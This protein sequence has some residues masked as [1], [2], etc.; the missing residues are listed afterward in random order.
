[1]NRLHFEYL[2]ESKK[3]EEDIHANDP[4]SKL[5]KTWS[6]IKN[7]LKLQPLWDIRDYLGEYVAFYYAFCGVLITS[8]W[9]PSLA[10]LAV[11]IWGSIN[12]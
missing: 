2:N 1:M 6:G 9:L 11:I 7:M 3:A 12:V 4:R 5:T 8:L 10:G